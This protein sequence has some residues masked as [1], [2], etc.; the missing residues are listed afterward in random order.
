LNPAAHFNPA[1]FA[2]LANG[3]EIALPMGRE[4]V[5]HVHAAD[6]A[7]AFM[8]AIANRWNAVGESFHV[9]SPPRFR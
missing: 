2:D 7:Q 3:Q 8:K 1:V 6:V 4:T 9:V 5:H